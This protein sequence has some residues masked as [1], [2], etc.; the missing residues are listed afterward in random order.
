MKFVLNDFSSKKICELLAYFNGD[1]PMNKVEK[2]TNRAYKLEEAMRIYNSD[3]LIIRKI[4][5]IRQ[6]FK[7]STEVKKNF[8]DLE[9]YQDDQVLSKY[10]E[11]SEMIYSFLKDAEETNLVDV[12]KDLLQKEEKGYFDYYYA[13]CQ[14]LDLYLSYTDSESMVEFCK[15]YNV[16]ENTVLDLM[17]ILNYLNPELYDKFLEKYNRDKEKRKAI[18]V[19]KYHNLYHGITTGLLP[20]EEKFDELEAF[21]NLP[22]YDEMTSKE[23]LSDFGVKSATYIDQ[24]LR[25]LFDYFDSS[26]T[27]L[28]IDYLHENKIIGNISSTMTEKEILSTNYVIRERELTTEDKEAIIKYMRDNKVPFI[29]RAFNVVRDRYLDGSLD[30]ASEKMLVKEGSNNGTK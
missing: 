6:I 7:S 18:T 4:D 3:M 14:L 10:Y 29:V 24:R 11:M 22:F 23:I 5:A 1:I 28:M 17:E 15:T 2:K 13:A 27:K 26:K 9:K 21:K 19:E 30:L 16:S 8:S 25:N 20:N 12:S